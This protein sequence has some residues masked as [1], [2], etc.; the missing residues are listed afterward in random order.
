MI[1]IITLYQ[2]SLHLANDKIDLSSNNEL[3]FV[4]VV[5]HYLCTS[6]SWHFMFLFLQLPYLLQLRLEV[7]VYLE[8]FIYH[9]LH[10]NN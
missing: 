10:H 7:Y 9:I 5:H 8:I 6:T 4:L 3:W 2:L 1:Q